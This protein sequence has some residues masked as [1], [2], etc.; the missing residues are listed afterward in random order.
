M[1]EI[2]ISLF[3]GFLIG[4]KLK[5]T[6]KIMKMNGKIQTLCLILLIFSMGMGIGINKEVLTSLPTIGLKAVI[7][8]CVTILCSVA[9]VYIFVKLFFPKEE[10]K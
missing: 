8:A 2:I 7:F 1:K 10:G 6:D 3:L 4:Y 5:F 9:V